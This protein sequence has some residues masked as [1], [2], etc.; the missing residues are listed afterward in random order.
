MA[1]ATYDT[2]RP[3]KFRFLKN[4]DNGVQGKMGGG[5]HCPTPVQF[6]PRQTM[7]VTALQNS[8]ADRT[9]QWILASALLYWAEKCD[10]WASVSPS[11]TLL[12]HNLVT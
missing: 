11:K 5:S 1:A 9:Q 10:S 12:V 6:C 4:F 8:T 2:V 7:W 3:A